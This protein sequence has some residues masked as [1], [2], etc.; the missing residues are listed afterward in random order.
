MSAKTLFRSLFGRAALAFG[1]ATALVPTAQAQVSPDLSWPAIFNPY[2]VHKIELEMSPAYWDT[3]RFDTSNSIVVP[4]QMKMAGMGPV[5]VDVRRKSSRALPSESDPRK[6]GLKVDIK[7]TVDWIGVKKLSLENSG[8]T[9]PV[10]EGVAW[11]MHNL[12]ANDAYQPALAAW[13]EV[14][15]NGEY[16]GVYVNN[17]QR[18]KQFLR[19]RRLYDKATTWMYKQDDIGLMERDGAPT[20]DPLSIDYD[21]PTYKALCYAP[22][23]PVT[24]TTAKKGQAKSGCSTPADNQL[25]LDLQTSIDMDMM[26]RQGAVD[27]LIDN[28]DGLFS[29]GKNFFVVDFASTRGLK[30][31]Y[32]PWDLDG[33]FRSTSAGIYGIPGKRGAVTQTPYQQIILNN[34]TFRTQYNAV[35]TNVLNVKLTDIVI[36]NYLRDAKAAVAPSLQRDPYHAGSVGDFDALKKWLE[37]R[38][39]SV[40]KQVTDN[41]PPA[42][43]K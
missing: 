27:A 42:P 39:V 13:V 38:R 29:K 7:G 41:G 16:L 4:A 26:L 43:R 18:D 32:F 37:S 24:T 30:R 8:D 31:L 33:V 34:P 3:I 10:K 6:V 22:F 40:L 25:A 12:A 1:L 11:G 35:M 28:G 5:A 36:G 9:S 2:T 15:V 19:N 20:E 17:E 23:R 21:S 14:H